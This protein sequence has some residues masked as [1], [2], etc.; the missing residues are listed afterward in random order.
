MGWAPS[1]ATLTLLLLLAALSAQ[2]AEVQP[3]GVQAKGLQP[4][5]AELTAFEGHRGAQQTRLLGL[6]APQRGRWLLRSC[7]RARLLQHWGALGLGSLL[8]GPIG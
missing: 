7:L 2:L 5:A 1:W 3:F 6:P 8:G 4:L